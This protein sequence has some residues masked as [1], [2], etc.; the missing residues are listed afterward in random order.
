M[1]QQFWS[2]PP[3]S[4]SVWAP[5]RLSVCPWATLRS[6]G[7]KA[8]LHAVKSLLKSKRSWRLSA[9]VSLKTR[10]QPLTERP[11]EIVVRLTRSRA[12]L[13]DSTTHSARRKLKGRHRKGVLL[14]PKAGGTHPFHVLIYSL[15]KLSDQK[16]MTHVTSVLLRPPKMAT[17][18]FWFELNYF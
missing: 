7:S 10:E 6:L 18:S 15:L 5:R 13:S 3:R 2:V 9:A 12:S 8:L 16:D 11:H 4:T 1:K 14:I 17:V